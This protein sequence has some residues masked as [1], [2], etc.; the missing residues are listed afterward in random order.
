[1]AILQSEIKTYKSAVVDD[2]GA[3]G[4]GKSAVA[5]DSAYFPDITGAERTSGLERY[6]KE[7]VA[8]ENKDGVT[9]QVNLVLFSARAFLKKL[10]GGEDYFRIFAEQTDDDDQTAA[11]GYAA[12]EWCGVATLDVDVTAGLSSFDIVT[13]EVDGSGNGGFSPNKSLRIANRLGTI[14]EYVTLDASAIVWAAGKATITITGALVNAFSRAAHDHTADIFSATTIGNTAANFGSSSEEVS[15]LVR[16]YAGTGAG[17]IRRIASHTVTALTVAYPFSIT[18]DGTS[19]F[20]VIDCYVS[21]VAD[22]SDMKARFFDNL[23]VE[24]QFTKID[25]VHYDEATTPL[26][27]YPV[28]TVNDTWTLTIANSGTE[29]TVSGASTGALA[30]GTIG[31]DYKPAN[32]ASFLFNLP[33]AGWGV[34]DPSDD[35]ETIIFKTAHSAKG[36]WVKH[37]VPAGSAA[38]GDDRALIGLGGDSV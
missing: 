4:G 21:Q 11:A 22:L 20:E 32:G 19:Q 30:N 16:I 2:T 7:F 27:L 18:P 3:N 1:M 8:N 9:D 37:I 17:Q 34:V 38:H 13:E 35:G 12:A 10:T 31:V 15:G 36:L 5:V 25:P 24:D 28:G 23:D 14:I 33:G 26:E 6:R 29:F